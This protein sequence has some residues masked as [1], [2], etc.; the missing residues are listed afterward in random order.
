ML[1][2]REVTA[3]MDAIS[4]A[5]GHEGLPKL[6]RQ[7]AEFASAFAASSD[8]NLAAKRVGITPQQAA[9]WLKRPEIQAHVQNILS[10]HQDM[11]ALGAVYTLA[12]AHAD[13]EMGKRMAANAGEWFKGVELQM[14]LH[15]LDQRK[16]EVNVNINNINARS[17]LEALDD[18][19]I[20]KLAGVSF[21]DLLPEA[22]DSE[23]IDGEG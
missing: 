20:M 21:A 11:L 16:T 15:G 10:R 7:E 13:L 17:Q 12:D 18:D 3:G 19:Q 6:N 22:I 2:D 14:K 5:T 8:K 1:D 23:V 9:Y 4:V